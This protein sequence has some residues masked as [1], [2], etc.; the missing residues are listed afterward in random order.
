[1]AGVT[2]TSKRLSGAFATAQNYA[3]I[4][5]F[6]HNSLATTDPD[7]GHH[8]ADN[9]PNRLRTT[10][11]RRVKN[12]SSLLGVGDTTI[13]RTAVAD[14][15]VSNPHGSPCN[16]SEMT[17]TP[18]DTRARTA[19][20]WLSSGQTW[21]APKLPKGNGDAYQNDMATNSDF[22]TNGYFYSVT[23]SQAVTNPV[24]EA[25]DPAL[26]NVGDRQRA[27]T[28]SQCGRAL[29]LTKGCRVGPLDALQGG[30]ESQH[31]LHRRCPLWGHRLR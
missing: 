29:T 28:W 16:E 22:D 23:L 6:Q 12:F 13:S 24:I 19:M 26:I 25:F 4:N 3:T 21:V 18:T 1:M 8:G 7:D 31:I 11:S 9:S 30:Y 15:R 5:G 10:V 17:W 2:K 27:T 14:F 20:E